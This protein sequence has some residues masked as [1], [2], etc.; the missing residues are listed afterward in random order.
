M[1][2]KILY[3]EILR[4]KGYVHELTVIGLQESLYSTSMGKVFLASFNDEENMENLCANGVPIKNQNNE[5]IAALS[6][7]FLKIS[8]SPNVRKT[9]IKDLLE[10]SNEVSKRS[11]YHPGIFMANKT[12]GS[13]VS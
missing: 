13:T 12:A 6:V 4:G 10:T 5:T 11:G 7:S 3:L 8:V 9:I 2:N 1:N